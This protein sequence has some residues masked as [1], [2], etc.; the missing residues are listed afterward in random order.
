MKYEFL[1]IDLDDTI[2]DFQQSAKISL[3]KASDDFSLPE[4]KRNYALYAE[5]NQ[6]LWDD[7]SLGKTT[8]EK[9]VVDRFRKYFE[10]INFKEDLAEEF[11]KKYE[12]YL[13][14]T[15]IILDDS[16]K[17]LKKI[18]NTGRK[19]YIITNG[20]A[21]VQHK[22]IKICKIDEICDGLFISDEIGYTKPDARFFDYILKKLPFVTRKKSLII[23]D[24]LLS[25][26][27]LGINSHVDTCF[28]NRK[29]KNNSYDLIP[30]YEISSLKELFDII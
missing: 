18:K 22:K 29:E 28:L 6:K 15:A 9:L 16:D 24:N 26:I 21:E 4:E 8:K 11:G 30:K 10:A 12:K 7:Y 17:T 5:I 3:S 27:G 2:Y 25:D 14:E 1:F 19:I 20:I 13:S 23:G